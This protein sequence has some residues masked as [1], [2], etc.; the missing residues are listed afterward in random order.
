MPF[1]K[2]ALHCHSTRSDGA[3]P[4][5][6]VWRWYRDAG[7][8]FAAITDHR[9]ATAAALPADLA[10]DFTALPG[11]EYNSTG[12]HGSVHV[13]GIGGTVDKETSDYEGGARQ[14]LAG[15]TRQ[16]RGAGSFTMINHPNWLWALAPE[17]FDGEDQAHAL[18]IWN[19]SRACN[20]LG[21]R[22][23]PS[24][25]ALWDRLLSRG[26]RL[27]GVATDDAHQYALPPKGRIWDI[28][29]GAWVCVDAP[30]ASAGN[31]M[32]G[33]FSGAFY[34]STG[35]DLERLERGSGRLSLKVLPLGRQVYTIRWIT[36]H[37]RVI[38]ETEAFE[39]ACELPA[40]EGYLRA[41]VLSSDGER[42]WTQP[43]FP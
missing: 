29:G 13:I 2:G 19:A 38:R 6:G 35:V 26:R 22:G 30:D 34:A 23:R 28:A 20:N 11:I 32:A 21:G 9:T 40:G 31:L 14:V 15:L 36:T 18:E 25:E 37:G 39:D 5:E 4:P 8:H 17:D 1:F 12:G 42:A 41:V 3:L 27:W 7:W 24:V 33:L 16:A 10:A 43:V